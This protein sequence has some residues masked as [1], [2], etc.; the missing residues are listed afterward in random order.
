MTYYRQCLK[1]QINPNPKFIGQLIGKSLKIENE[2]MSLE[3]CKAL[4]ELLIQ[5]DNLEKPEYQIEELVVDE[6]SIDDQRL[7]VIL[8]ALDQ[9]SRKH[10]KNISIMNCEFRLKSVEPLVSILMRTAPNHID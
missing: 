3:R 1:G 9:Q 5:G 10:L 8:K 6:C 4:S 7:A 2:Y